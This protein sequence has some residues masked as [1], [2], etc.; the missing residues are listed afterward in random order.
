MV[1][2]LEQ[3]DITFG[4]SPEVT[5]ILSRQKQLT[6]YSFVS[7]Q[8]SGRKQDLGDLSWHRY[9][10]RRKFNKLVFDVLAK[11]THQ[12]QTFTEQA[13]RKRRDNCAGPAACLYM[14]G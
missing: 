14:I 13:R 11:Y 6:F 9:L 1:A 7:C 12:A 2:V 4:P 8:K 3:S 10:W 5:L